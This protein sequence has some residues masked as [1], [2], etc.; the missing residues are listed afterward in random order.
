MLD[1]RSWRSYTF[2]SVCNGS[3][4]L[5]WARADFLHERREPPPASQ[6]GFSD[7]A[8]DALR[9]YDTLVVKPC[10]D[11]TCVHVHVHAHVPCCS[12]ANERAVRAYAVRG[13]AYRRRRAA[14]A[15]AAEP[16]P[17]RSTCA[18]CVLATQATGV[19]CRVPW[20]H[21][22]TRASTC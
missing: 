8:W 1:R 17:T 5:S 2:A 7:F 20:H 4:T 15:P 21:R 13:Y 10:V 6:H 11:M 19:P 12:R 18:A 3:A 16:R 22:S 9:G 14:V